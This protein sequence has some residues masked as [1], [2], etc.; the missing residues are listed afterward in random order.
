MFNAPLSPELAGLSGP[1]RVLVAMALP[2]RARSRLVTCCS[3]RRGHNSVPA[4]CR[5]RLSWAPST[6]FCQQESK[7]TCCRVLC[8]ANKEASRDWEHLHERARGKSFHSA[9]A[10]FA[11]LPSE[12]DGLECLQGLLIS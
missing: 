7:A 6:E 10:W 2:E 4:V 3:H 1:A 8:A 12:R 11:P 5:L 9:V